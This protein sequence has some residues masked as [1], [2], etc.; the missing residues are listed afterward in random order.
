M[1]A[2]KLFVN[3][4]QASLQSSIGNYGANILSMTTTLLNSYL[5]FAKAFNQLRLFEFISGPVSYAEN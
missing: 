3:I 1:R 5:K 4:W 2:V